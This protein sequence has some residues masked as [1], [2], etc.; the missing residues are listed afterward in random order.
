MTSVEASRRLD[1]RFAAWQ[2]GHI[3]FAE[4]DLSVQGWINHVC[5]ADTWGLRRTVLDRLAWVPAA[6]AAAAKPRSPTG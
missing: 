6:T 5:Y 3:S 2:S 1:E 4:F